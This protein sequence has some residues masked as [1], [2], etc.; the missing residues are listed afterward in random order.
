MTKPIKHV[1]KAIAVAANA[2]WHVYDK[3]NSINRNPCF[4]PKWS[5]KPLLK[6]WE[7]QKPKLGWPRETDSLCPK[8]IPE[9]RQQILDG[10]MPVEILRNEKVGE[11]KANIIE[12]DG[13]IVMVKECPI[14]GQFEDLMSIDPAFSKH[15]EDVFPGRDIRAHNDEKLHDHGTSTITHGRGSVLTIDLT[16]RCNMMCDPCFMDANQVGYV[17]ELSWEE[18][19]TLLDNAISIKPRRQLSVQ[20][21]GGEPTLSPYFLDAVKYC[22][23]IGYQSVQAATNGIEFAKRPEFAKQAAEAGLR[24]AYLQFDGIGNEANSHRAVGNLFD[25]KLR[26]IENLYSAGV[27]IVPVITLINGVNNEQVGAVVRFALDNPKKIPFLSFQPVSFTG[28]DE[29]V[30]Q[31]RREAQRYTLS[32]LAHDVKKQTGLGEP[33]RDWFPI[34]FMST[35]SDFAD[36]VHGPNADWGQ[37]SC[38]CHPELR[39]RHGGDVRQGNQGIPPGDCVPERGP[40][41][42]GRGSHQ[43]R[44]AQQEDVGDRR[45]AGAAAQLQS[46]RSSHAL[47]P[48]RP[49]R[50]VRQVL[51]HDQQ[52]VRQGHRRPH[53]GRH[54]EAPRGPLELPVRGRHVVPGSVQLRFPPHRAVHHSLRDAGRRDQL[55]RV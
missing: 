23:K 37:L 42:Q 19:K 29:A 28:R 7:K 21:S 24:Y 27:D 26:A 2:A 14:H 39:H 32:H 46:L 5:D 53:H 20:F 18:I 48:E 33:I 43:R 9:I 31:E 10:K 51:R 35:F 30:T 25:V 16:N 36:L 15:L 22:R 38:G 49:D 44:R 1:E 55:L 6:S 13:K 52:E 12:K 8:C 50:Q 11:I 34:S 45:L 54:P 3:L 17:H 40:A 4:T 47:P 41:G